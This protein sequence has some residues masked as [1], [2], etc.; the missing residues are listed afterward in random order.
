MERKLSEERG[1]K[2]VLEIRKSTEE[3]GKREK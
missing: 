3:E 2:Q 1:K